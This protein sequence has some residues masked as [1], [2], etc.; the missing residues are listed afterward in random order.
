MERVKNLNRYQK[1]ILLLLAVMVIVFGVIYGIVTSRVGFLYKD[2]ILLPTEENGNTV[3]SG[4]IRGQDCRFTVTTDKIVT[5]QCD[6]TVYGPYTA[7]E[8]P[9]AIP[10]GEEPS[11]R[12]RGIEVREGDEIL[13]RGSVY[14]A[15][16]FLMLTNE[17]GSYAG[18]NITAT[19]SDGTVIDE[20][21]EII[22]P[23]EP[24]AED[25]LSLTDG[26][27]LTKKGHWLAWFMGVIVSV[28][29][30]VSILFAD[31][32]F[33]WNLAF[34]IRNFDCAEPSDWEIA[35]RHIGWTVLTITALILY[36][37]G[38]QGVTVTTW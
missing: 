7:K 15:D 18:F 24:S 13:F 17:D 20:N 10:E 12:L 37:A 2:T 38:L 1:G 21:G 8:D 23:L 19:M 28:M 11:D 32:L 34:Q 14:Q 27:E 16:T 22:D 29:T 4:R 31:E 5:F 35:S 33:R 6:E 25:I 36:I 26:P 3:Y 30:A 9:S